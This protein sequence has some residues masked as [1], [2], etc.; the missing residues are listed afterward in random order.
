MGDQI[1]H[2]IPF[3][4]NTVMLVMI[5]ALRQEMLRTIKVAS[6]G[7]SVLKTLETTV[8]KTGITMMIS[9]QTWEMV[10]DTITTIT[11]SFGDW[12]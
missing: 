10:T 6:T 4:D 3:T 9:T 11:K 12:V 5:D 1:K 7:I 2:E 8:M